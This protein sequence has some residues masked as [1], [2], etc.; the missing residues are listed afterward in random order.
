MVTACQKCQVAPGI[1]IHSFC[2]R[3]LLQ[4]KFAFVTSKESYRYY[5]F[6]VLLLDWEEIMINHLSTNL[7]IMRL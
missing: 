6:Q 4:V 7:D 2:P 5:I 3:R 1:S